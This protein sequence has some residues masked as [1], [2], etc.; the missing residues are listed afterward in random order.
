MP[1]SVRARQIWRSR[2][3]GHVLL[4]V[5]AFS[6]RVHRVMERVGISALEGIKES[7]LRAV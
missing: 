1:C 5:G 7:F 2:G 3:Q 4:K 6:D